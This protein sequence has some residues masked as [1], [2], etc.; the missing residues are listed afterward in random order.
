MTY[1]SLSKLWNITANFHTDFNPVSVWTYPVCFWK[2]WS[3]LWIWSP[4]VGGPFVKLPGF[5][6]FLPLTFVLEREL[7]RSHLTLR[8]YDYLSLWEPKNLIKPCTDLGIRGYSLGPAETS[9]WSFSLHFQNHLSWFLESQ[10]E[11]ESWQC[12]GTSSKF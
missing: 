2:K 6:P 3:V 5:W 12:S 1:F 11:Y 8:F 9:L 4:R 10:L 7:L